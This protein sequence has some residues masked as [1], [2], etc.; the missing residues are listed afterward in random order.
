[1][2]TLQQI[3]R[4]VGGLVA[5][6]QLRM[7]KGQQVQTRWRQEYL[8]CVFLGAEWVF[9]AMEQE[10]SEGSGKYTICRAK[11]QKEQQ[12]KVGENGNM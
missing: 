11:M 2:F 7:C 10:V 3:V 6:D 1:M 8:K 4:F 9:N 12:V 5:G